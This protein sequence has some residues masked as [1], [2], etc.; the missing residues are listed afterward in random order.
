MLYH[1]TRQMKFESIKIENILSFDLCEFQFK[2]YNVIVGANNTGKTNLLR[3]LKIIMQRDSLS[4][5]QIPKEMKLAQ[6]KKSKIELT[7]KMSDEEI[8][9][10][11][12]CLLNKPIQSQEFDEELKH[13]TVILNWADLVREASSP[14]NIIFCFGNGMTVTTS[15]NHMIMFNWKQLSEDR[16]QFFKSLEY[17]GYDQIRGRIKERLRTNPTKD[18]MVDRTINSKTIN[19]IFIDQSGYFEFKS[20]VQYN[21]EKPTSHAAELRNYLGHKEAS[22]IILPS[23]LISHMLRESFI[24]VEEI[25][26][27]Y[28]ELTDRLFHLKMKDENRYN[29]I[30]ETFEKIFQ[31]TKIKVEQSPEN[32]NI[33]NI[34]IMENE[35]KYKIEESASGHFAVIH[36]LY[37][38]LNKQ[39]KVIMLDEPEIHFHPVKIR[40]IGQELLNLIKYNHNQIIVASH[41]SKFVDF[42]LLDPAY[43]SSLISVAKR[44]ATSI[45]SQPRNVNT[46]LGPHLFEP[47]IFFGNLVFLVEGSDDEFTMR[48]ISD[49]LDG[50]FDR[51]GIVLVNCWG[52]LNIDP[53]TILLDAYAIQYVGLAD[54]EYSGNSSEIIKLDDDLEEEL[55]KIGWEGNKRSLTPSVAYCFIIDLLQTREGLNKIKT[56][57]IWSCIELIAK[58]IDADIDSLLSKY[59]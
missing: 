17:L 20:N 30:Q 42:R 59:E 44:G 36:I 16:N 1:I 38:I 28:Q 15:L 2:D 12:E 11:L 46:S 50:L 25:H 34:W 27:N 21:F 35:Q 7:V 6:S 55:R 9:L 33:K 10:L 48:A 5:L 19:S 3:I 40:L 43:L 29:L 51:Y 24:Y 47:E 31:K 14:N 53:Y 39:N 18:V 41:S 37:S 8:R 26:P 22:T 4:S 54:K 52:H 32:E 56:T 13:M 57:K 23:N 49:S 45:V 58:Q